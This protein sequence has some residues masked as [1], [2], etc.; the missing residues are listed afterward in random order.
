MD[1]EVTRREFLKRAVVAAA[2]F[3]P[4]FTLL[5]SGPKELERRGAAKKVIVVGAG[6]AG[7]VAGYELTRAG[8]DVTIL[9][10]QSRPGGRVLTLREPFSDGLYAEAGPVS[11]ASVHRLV[12]KYVKLF[13]LPLEPNVA[14]RHLASVY[15]LRGRRFEVKPGSKPPWPLDLTL[16][17]RK[18]GISGMIRKYVA[19]ALKEMGD[20][21]RLDWPPPFL[22][23]Y[24]RVTYAEFLRQQGASPGAVALLRLG[25]LDVWG[26]GVDHV[27][28]LELLREQALHHDARYWY[29]IPGG[30]DLLP[31]AFADRL[32]KKIRYAAP[33]VRIEQDARNVRA[34]FLEGG[35]RQALVADRLISTV[36]FPVLKRT[37]VSPP[38]SPEKQRAIER[39]PYTSITRVYLESRKRFWIEQ[40][41]SGRSLTDLPIQWMWDMTPKVTSPRGILQS[42]TSGEHARQIAAMKESE[43]IHCVLDQ[44]EKI[45]PG[46]RENFERGSS[47]SWDED[48]WARGAYACFEP[49]QMQTLLPHIARPEGR[50]HFAGEHASAWFGWQEGAL[51]S[52]YRAA[53]EVNE[54]IESLSE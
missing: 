45:L 15:Y 42:F 11:F 17:E 43:R 13:G 23:K 33:V 12:M 51:E 37:E 9:E 35:S 20:A 6:L 32:V 19:P 2:R 8:H 25:H 48:K 41:L 53:L 39:L 47:K 54:A 46:I 30:N 18:L 22:E 5:A 14:P 49:G 26:D 34:V 10:A 3:G 4:S 36:P 1:F 44:T 29:M 50:V 16:E 52:G 27:S 38:F 7:L 40:G 21:S 24:D 28:A 31:Q